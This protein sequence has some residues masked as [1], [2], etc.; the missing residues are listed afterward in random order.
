MHVS[1]ARMAE[2]SSSVGERE[3]PPT[4][5]PQ[6]SGS[7]RRP[8]SHR[9]QAGSDRYEPLPSIAQLPGWI[10][11]RLPPA[12][13]VVL[14]L[15]PLVAVGLVLTLGPDIERSKDERAKAEAERIAQARAE[16]LER[17]R[18]EQRPRFA[19][20]EPAATSIPARGRLL[21]DATRSVER[22]A[23]RRVE[24]EQ[25][26]GPIRRVECEP[27][28]RTV[29]SA[30]AEHDPSRRAGRYACLAVTSE[31]DATAAHGAGAI[32]HPY[33]MRIDFATGRYAFCKVS[34]RAGEGAIATTP[35]VPVAAACGG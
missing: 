11:R 12:G 2:N 10:W 22:D 31:I 6:P 24:A 27:Y 19:R 18:E 8:A 5:R 20:G 25:L 15:I 1:Y 30:G 9:D 34:G 29:E 14:G 13:K 3:E 4:D 35:F 23:R 28:P 7:R 21:A 26:S 33:R 16:R 17:L 32:G